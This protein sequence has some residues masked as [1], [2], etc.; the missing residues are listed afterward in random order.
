MTAPQATPLVLC[1]GGTGR[2]GRLLVP[3]LLQRGARV[4]VL[5]RDPGR[6]RSLLGPQAELAA[7]DLADA[8]SLHAALQG[9]THAFV[10]SPIAPDLAAR[11]IAAVQAARAQGVGHVVKLSGSDWTIAPAGALAAASP[12]SDAGAAHREVEQALAAT[13][14]SHVVLRPNAWMQVALGRMARELGAG[15]TITSAYRQ[16]QVS[17]IDAR[18]IADVAVR[19]L[20]DAPQLQPALPGPWVLTGA[21]AL[22]FTDIAA[23]A[24]SLTGR[25]IATAPALAQDAA[26]LPPFVQQA[27]AQFAALIAQGRAASATGT[28]SRV[29]GRAPRTVRDFVGQ[30]LGL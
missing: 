22:D 2:L 10:L 6:A 25:P 8:A 17:Y 24:Q 15:D 19:A 9:A 7:G 13:G 28:V 29:L 1:T 11:Q 14:L 16:A 27:H 23:I 12:R 26:H 30:E 21:Q 3:R 5:T 4:R 20:L 18:D